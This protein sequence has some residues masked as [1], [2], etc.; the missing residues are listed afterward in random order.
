MRPLE[1]QEVDG[2]NIKMDL[3]EITWRVVDLIRI[4]QDRDQWRVFLRTVMKT[5]IP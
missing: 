1:G 5:H 4:S 2:D 3:K